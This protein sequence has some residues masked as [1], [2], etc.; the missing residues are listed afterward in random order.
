[1]KEGKKERKK[2]LSGDFVDT[3]HH[4]FFIQLAP[5]TDHRVGNVV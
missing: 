1:M 3:P 4:R 5:D 2:A